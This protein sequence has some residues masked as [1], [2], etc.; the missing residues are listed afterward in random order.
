M[1]IFLFFFLCLFYNRH[2]QQ[3]YT[4]ITDEMLFLCKLM[5]CNEKNAGRR[6]WEVCRA[7][8]RVRAGCPQFVIRRRRSIRQL[9]VVGRY[10]S[11]TTH[12]RRSVAQFTSLMHPVSGVAGPLAAEGG[13]QICRPFV[14]GFWNWRACL[15]HKSHVMSTVTL[16]SWLALSSAQQYMLVAGIQAYVRSYV[17]SADPT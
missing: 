6:R 7:A 15:K 5:K 13:G 16:V 2:H 8:Q 14:L 1:Y 11:D 4:L 10:Q 9:V 17:Y 3:P 12:C